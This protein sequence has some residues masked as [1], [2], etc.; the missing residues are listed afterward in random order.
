MQDGISV[1]AEVKGMAFSTYKENPE[2][3]RNGNA[4]G[5]ITFLLNREIEIGVGVGLI[6]QG[7]MPPLGVERLEAVAQ[8][9]LP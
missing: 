5:F 6:L 3:S 4:P 1:Y 2:G 7:E 8:H 9:R